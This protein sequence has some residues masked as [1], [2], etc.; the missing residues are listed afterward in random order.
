MHAGAA[1]AAAGTGLGHALAQAIGGRYGVPHGAANAVCLPPALRFNA[2]AAAGALRRLGEAMGTDDAAGR[3]QELAALAG[4]ARLRDLGVPREELGTV[5]RD[6]LVRSGARANPRAA[7][8]DE[9]VEL[10]DGVW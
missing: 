10:L 4:F 8:A 7:S 9:V 1:L 6:A 3:A 5:A 2:S